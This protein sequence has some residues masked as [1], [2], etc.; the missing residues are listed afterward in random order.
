MN[1]SIHTNA[2]RSL[3]RQ[4][5]GGEADDSYARTGDAEDTI[6]RWR[7]S[8]AKAGDLD[9]VE[10]IDE[11]G[12]RKAARIYAQARSERSGPEY[13]PDAVMT[14]SGALEELEAIT[15]RDDFR[16]RVAGLYREASEA[17]DAEMEKIARLVLDIGKDADP[18]GCPEALDCAAA[19]RDAEALS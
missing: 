6:R 7:A 11:L 3:A 2:I 1:T 15:R 16:A 4:D 8:G 13:T 9:L 12:I 10:I 19:I 17:G 14:P 5:A 18:A